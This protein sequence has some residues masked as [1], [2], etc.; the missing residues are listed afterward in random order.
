MESEYIGDYNM[1][2]CSEFT[3]KEIIY[4]GNKISIQLWDTVLVL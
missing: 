4:K 3:T 2:I 1:T